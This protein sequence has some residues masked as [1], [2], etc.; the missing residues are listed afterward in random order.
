MD[1]SYYEIEDWK[2]GDAI[3]SKE[4]LAKIAKR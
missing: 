4:K 3:T 1:D 2:P